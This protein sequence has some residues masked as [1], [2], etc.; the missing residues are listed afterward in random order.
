MVVVRGDDGVK[1]TVFDEI[2]RL[3]QVVVGGARLENRSLVISL[4]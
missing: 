3:N 1:Q 2:I 4:L